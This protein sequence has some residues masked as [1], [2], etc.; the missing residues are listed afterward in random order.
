MAR[1]PSE[2]CRSSGRLRLVPEIMTMN[3]ERQAWLSVMQYGKSLRYAGYA[4]RNDNIIIHGSLTGDSAAFTAYFVVN[5][6]VAA[7]ATLNKDPQVRP[8]VMSINAM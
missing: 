4:T 1:R 8:S 5:G 2:S 3:M 6:R 7:V